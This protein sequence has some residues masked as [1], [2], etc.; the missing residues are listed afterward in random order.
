VRHSNLWA[1]ALQGEESIPKGLNGQLGQGF[2]GVWL[3]RLAVALKAQIKK[4]LCPDFAQGMSLQ[5]T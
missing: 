5:F 3:R 2:P 4:A 1:A